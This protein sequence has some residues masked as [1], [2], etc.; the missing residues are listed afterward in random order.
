MNDDKTTRR[1]AAILGALALAPGLLSAAAEAS[2]ESFRYRAETIDALF[3]RA[4]KLRTSGK[5]TADSYL[6]AL[7]LLRAEELEIH[8]QAAA[9][10]F[11][12]I[13]ESNYWHRSRLK[14][15]SSLE[16]ELRRLK[17]GMAG[18]AAAR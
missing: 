15:P 18:G 11:K 1:R 9:H 13:T 6:A 12:D 10:S 16:Q 3:A 2:D 5:L 17:D 4:G 8:R 7:D 14:F